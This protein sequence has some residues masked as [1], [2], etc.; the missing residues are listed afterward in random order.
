MLIKSREIIAERGYSS[1]LD[2]IRRFRQDLSVGTLGVEPQRLSQFSDFFST[3]E[4]RD[5]LF[6]VQEHRL[7][8]RQIESFLADFGLRFIGFE[9]DRSVLHQYRAR[10]T[11]DLS[12]TNLRNWASFEA[13]HPDTF[14]AMYQF[15]IQKCA[16][17][18]LPSP[19]E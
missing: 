2:D 18:D 14:A 13:E 9:M 19:A 17:G 11:D 1:T 5:L 3:S 12:A 4:C 16:P 6:H 8:L 10:F 15:W 7:T